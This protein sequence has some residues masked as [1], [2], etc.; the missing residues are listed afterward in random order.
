MNYGLQHSRDAKEECDGFCGA[1]WAGDTN[2]QKSVSSYLFQ[3]NGCCQLE[4]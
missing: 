1:D 3:W 4:K 2:D